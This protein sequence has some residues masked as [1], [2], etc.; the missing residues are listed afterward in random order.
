MAFLGART[1]SSTAGACTV[2]SINRCIGDEVMLSQLHP[3]LYRLKCPLPGLPLQYL[4]S[5]IIVSENRSLMIDTGINHPEC[6]DAVT[7]ALA[8]LNV[9]LAVTDFLI[10]HLH[11]DH[12]GLLS[13]L[14]TDTSR[15]FTGAEDIR[16]MQQFLV[17]GYEPM[18]RA[19]IR[20]GLDE[21]KIRSSV[22]RESVYRF[23]LDWL[24]KVVRLEDGDR[25]D[26]GGY[27]F[28]VIETPGHSPGHIC[29]YEFVKKILVSGDHILSGISPGIQ[30]WEEG[31]NPL[32]MYLESLDRIRSLEV[33]SV[34]PGHLEPIHDCRRRIDEIKTHHENRLD[35]IL[36][37]L[38]MGEMS[39][40]EIAS[41][42]M[43]GAAG[44]LGLGKLPV[45]QQLM[46]LGE[47]IA[48]LRFLE[49]KGR[50]KKR[51]AGR[52]DSYISLGMPS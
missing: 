1:G 29:L 2:E 26:L 14:M 51:G 42:M 16:Q 48:H 17:D 22:S 20:N 3:N 23:E 41:A 47:T 6:L 45:T 11:V 18:I 32:G 35:E 28:Q 34:L 21:K 40:F 15:I 13:E 24:D 44:R 43:W 36:N 30:C 33:E 27:S 31:K 38:G 19:G 10:T 8:Q 12:F 46:A 4:N 37:I 7:G 49:E 52:Q 9:D 25:I 50:I 39:V 5:Y